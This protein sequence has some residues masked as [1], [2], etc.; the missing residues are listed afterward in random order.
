MCQIMR[1]FEQPPQF[2]GGSFPLNEFGFLGFLA[3]L[4]KL[5]DALTIILV[6]GSGWVV[7]DG[8][9]NHNLFSQ[10]EVERKDLQ[11]DPSRF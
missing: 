5:R 4:A 10:L 1:I 6:V 11:I 9:A 7:C 2:R 3:E 8:L